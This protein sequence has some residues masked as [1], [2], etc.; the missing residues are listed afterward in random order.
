MRFHGLDLNL[1]VALDALLTER[2]VSHAAR[3]LKM[4]QATLSSALGRLRHHFKDDLLIQVGRTMVPTQMADQLRMPVHSLL[5]QAETLALRRTAFDPATATG[6][7]TVIALDATH[8]VFTA[9]VS[10]RLSQDAPGLSLSL[11]NFGSA[12]EVSRLLNDVHFMI[13]PPIIM[14]P[15][16]PHIPLYEDDLVCI[17][18]AG[19]PAF[20]NGLTQAEFFASRHV[21][22]RSQGDRE[23]ETI[24]ATVLR[25]LGEQRDAA[26]KTSSYLLVPNL[27]VGTPYLATIPRSLATQAARSLPLAILPFPFAAQAMYEHLQWHHSLDGD[28]AIRWL[29]KY[30]QVVA[31]DMR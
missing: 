7:F 10:Q 3:R 13:A 29:R 12:R 8:A 25:L 28:P 30:M 31:Q 2:N 17:C 20:A 23:T 11:V 1:L 18:D 4:S 6:E 27:V 21:I 19:N 9:K 26:I 5:M 15:D 14:L 22:V 24:D 16:E